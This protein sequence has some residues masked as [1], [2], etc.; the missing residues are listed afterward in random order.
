MDGMKETV[1]IAISNPGKY[2][3]NFATGRCLEVTKS[4]GFM[5]VEANGTMVKHTKDATEALCFVMNL[6]WDN[7]P[8]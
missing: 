4:M 6:P 7:N 5:C 2:V 8:I 3:K 1:F